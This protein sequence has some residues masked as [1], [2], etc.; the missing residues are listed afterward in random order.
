MTRNILVTGGA[1]YIGSHT[2]KALHKAGFQPIVLDDLFYGHEAFVRWGPLIRGDVRDL[3]LVTRLLRDN[4]IEAVMHF[5]ALAYVGESVIEPG[6]YYDNNVV[7]TLRLLQAME[8]AGCRRMVFSSTCAIYGEAGEAPISEASVPRPVNPYGRS[9]LVCEMMLQD[10]A[11]ATDL[12]FT[13]LR[14]FNAAGDD[15][16]GELGE[17]RTV[18]T[19]L[20]PRAMMALRGH[21]QDFQVFGSDFPTPDGTAIRDYVHVT[22]LAEAHVAA[23][24]RMLDGAAGAATFNLGAGVGFSVREVLSAIERVSGRRLPQVLGARRPGDP[25]RLVADPALARREL[26]FA[27]RLSDLETIVQTAWRWHEKAHPDRA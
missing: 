6:K 24:R 2:C 21:L 27:P 9:K 11:A 5:A 14:Y 8:A 25:A 15:P 26:G 12:S 17:D 7:G 22:D 23:L 4:Q 3:D 18:E 19:H 16:D 10:L 20:I 13:A 1:G